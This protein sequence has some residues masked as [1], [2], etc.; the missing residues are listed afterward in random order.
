VLRAAKGYDGNDERL[1]FNSSVVLTDAEHTLLGLE[2]EEIYGDAPRRLDRLPRNGSWP[3]TND[4]TESR[5]QWSIS[6]STQLVT[7]TEAEGYWQYVEHWATDEMPEP[8]R[9][10]WVTRCEWRFEPGL[11]MV[12]AV[13][14]WQYDDPEIPTVISDDKAAGLAS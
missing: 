5:R 8:S 2:L 3:T 4:R 7:C 13:H 14:A 10:Y 1:W 6:P 9:D 12:R 11:G